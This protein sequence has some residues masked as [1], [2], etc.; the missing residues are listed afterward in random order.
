MIGTCSEWLLAICFQLYILSF[1]VELRHAYCKKRNLFKYNFQILGHAPKLKLIA[2][3]SGSESAVSADIFDCCVI[4]PSIIGRKNTNVADVA[5][6]IGCNLDEING[7]K[8]DSA[9][10]MN[11]LST[12]DGHSLSNS[13]LNSSPVQ[14]DDIKT[15]Y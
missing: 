15:K 13:S 2:F 11:T 4:P 1:A 14:L 6:V 9:N 7:A 3:L 12:T 5:R 8:I 10:P